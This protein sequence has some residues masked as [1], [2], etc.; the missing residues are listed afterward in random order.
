MVLHLDWPDDFILCVDPNVTQE[1]REEFTEKYIVE[2]YSQKFRVCLVE[3]EWLVLFNVL[4]I[5]DELINMSLDIRY[6]VSMF[7]WYVE[8]QDG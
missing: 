4:R 7:D 2:K 1:H 8:S 3:T 6:R 5:Y